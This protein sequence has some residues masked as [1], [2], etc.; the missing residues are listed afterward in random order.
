METVAPSFLDKGLLNIPQWDHLGEDLKKRDKS[1]PLLPGTLAI[2]TLFR[3]CLGGHKPRGES[4]IQEGAEALEEVKEERSS[5]ASERNSS[6][7][8]EM[9][10]EELERKVGQK[11]EPLQSLPT[12]THSAPPPYNT[13]TNRDICGCHAPTTESW[14]TKWKEAGLTSA[15]KS[16]IPPAP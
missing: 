3:G 6:S 8:E 14:T 12:T 15:F 2:W 10:G 7:K 4:A 1:K 16:L 5:R 13:C 9:S 11:P